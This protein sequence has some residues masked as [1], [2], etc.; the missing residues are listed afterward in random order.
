VLIIMV[1]GAVTGCVWFY[2]TGLT[3]MLAVR[4]EAPS[5]KDAEIMQLRQKLD[6]SEKHP[7]KSPSFSLRQQQSG[8]NNVQTGPITQAPC[9]VAQF[10]GEGNQTTTNCGTVRSLTP[11]EKTE[12]VENLKKG[13]PGTATVWAV[14]TGQNLGIEI[15]DA[16]KAAGWQMQEPGVQMMLILQPMREDIDV[17]VHGEP[18][19]TAQFSTS[20]PTTV[21]LIH[22]LA[23]LRRFKSGGLGR[24]ENVA[25]GVTKIS[26]GPPLPN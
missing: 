19:D 25:K 1:A 9:S 24:S 13:P 3:R 17:F 6:E 16:L 15:Y 10:G 7:S 18:G 20:D 4:Y 5:T 12:F 14:E 11:Q 26:V 23:V 2:T 22:S 21:T 8:K